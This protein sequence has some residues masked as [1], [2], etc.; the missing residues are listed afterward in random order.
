ME[1]VIFCIWLQPAR[2]T[3]LGG[4]CGNYLDFTPFPPCDFQCPSHWLKPTRSQSGRGTVDVV[5]ISQLLWTQ[6]RTNSMESG[7]WRSRWKIHYSIHQFCPSADKKFTSA[8]KE[9]LKVPSGVL[10]SGDNASL[11]ILPPDTVSRISRQIIQCSLSSV[12]PWEENTILKGQ[13]VALL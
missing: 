6:S 9:T 1:A 8:I 12:S 10:S 11:S 4:G 3:L 7:F 5:Y 2:V 13:T